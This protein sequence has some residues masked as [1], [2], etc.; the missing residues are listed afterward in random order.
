MN[1]VSEK[2]QQPCTIA[3]VSASAFEKGDKVKTPMN[4]MVGTITRITKKGVAW[5]KI[6]SRWGNHHRPV[7]AK[8]YKFE[9]EAL[10]HWR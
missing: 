2:H 4:G 9:L 8:T 10:E 7:T 5:V 3:G 6:K 1:T